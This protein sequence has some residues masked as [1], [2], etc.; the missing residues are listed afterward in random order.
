MSL[1]LACYNEILPSFNC[2]VGEDDSIDYVTPTGSK[3]PATVSGG[4]LVLP[5]KDRLR[6]GFPEELFPFHPL[7]ESMARQGTSPVIQFM[8]RSAKSNISYAVVVM[9]QHLLEI[10]C[11]VSIHKDLPP[12]CLDFL[13]KLSDCD[14]EKNIKTVFE[15]VIAAALKKNRLVTVYLKNG[16]VFDGKKVNRSCIIR[17]PLLEDLQQEG[18]DVLGVT[19]SKKQRKILIALFKLIV[20]FG[21]SPEEYSHGT[22]SRHAPYLQCLLISYA[23]ILKV[24]NQCINNYAVPL[25][26]PVKP[27]PVY[28]P[29]VVETF[30]KARAEI[31][32]PALRGNE[33]GVKE[34]DDEVSETQASDQRKVDQANADSRNKQ[35]LVPQATRN[36]VPVA[37]PAVANGASSMADFMKATT[38][39]YGTQVNFNAQPNNNGFNTQ[40]QQTSLFGNNQQQSS[41]GFNQPQQ[42]SNSLFGNNNNVSQHRMPWEQQQQPQQKTLF[43][44]PVPQPGFNSGFNNSGNGL[45]LI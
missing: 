7:C 34:T 2:F 27:F 35:T 22:V 29:A 6:K 12:D 43:G 9:A 41:F 15:K 33:G 24:L 30:E 3:K 25:Q 21:D 45:G 31:E 26:L 11:D 8:Q 23:K 44:Q 13:V 28:D 40:P 16:G 32:I 5:T 18:K 4:R 14:K 1:T 20:P 38:P 36:A 10:A 42:Q 19:V 39:N 17:I 37:E